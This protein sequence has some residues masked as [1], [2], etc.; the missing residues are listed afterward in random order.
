MMNEDYRNSRGTDD[1]NPYY[2]TY[3]TQSPYIQEPYYRDPRAVENRYPNPYDAG[4]SQWQEERREGIFRSVF[5]FRVLPI[6]L[7]LLSLSCLFTGWVR[8]SDNLKTDLNEITGYVSKTSTF[9]GKYVGIDSIGG[10]DTTELEEVIE[11]LSDG[12]LSPYEICT[13]VDTVQ[14]ASMELS[15]ICDRLNIQSDTVDMLNSMA[16]GMSLF[17][18]LCMILL[19]TAVLTIILILFR[20]KI[21]GNWFF[22]AA[23]AALLVC[24]VLLMNAVNQKMGAD[25]HVGLTMFPFIAVILSLPLIPYKRKKQ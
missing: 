12:E 6:L 8:F 23:A 5:L 14:K 21:L 1:F 10:I 16:E 4:A 15:Q 24:C 19:G 7:I 13:G 17:R 9:L 18:L 25:Y 20:V 2:G 3:Y 22:T 11:I